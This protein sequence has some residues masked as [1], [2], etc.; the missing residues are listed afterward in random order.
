MERAFADTGYW[1]ALLNSH[2]ELH[3]KAF[4]VSRDFGLGQIVTS[5]MVLTEFLNSFRRLRPSAT[6]DSGLRISEIVIFPQ[7]THLFT[8][9][10]QR[11]R[12]MADKS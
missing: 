12:A 10:L 3:Q 4:A 5:E 1:I 7:T 6:S 9:A 11:Y 8:S 2:D